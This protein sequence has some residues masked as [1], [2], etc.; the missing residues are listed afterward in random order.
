[1]SETVDVLTADD[2]R[3]PRS[4]PP[5]TARTRMVPWRSAMASLV[6][7]TRRRVPWMMHPVAQRLRK[8]VPC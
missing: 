6:S 1:M 2:D 3:P 5:N 7:G 8:E 4:S